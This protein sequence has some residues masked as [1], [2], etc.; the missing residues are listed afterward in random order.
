MAFSEAYLKWQLIANSNPPPSAKP[1]TAAI[2]GF[3]LPRDAM[4]QQLQ[5]QLQTAQAS[6]QQIPPQAVE[7]LNVFMSTPTWEDVIRFFRDDPMR[8]YK[9]DVETN[10]TVDIEATEDKAQVG[11]FLN[12]MAQFLN[13]IAPIVQQAILP[14]EAA[15]SIMLAVTKRFRFGV[16]VED[17]L[18]AMTAPPPPQQEGAP[19]APQPTQAEMAAQETALKG[20]QLKQQTLQMEAEYAK[21]EHAYKMEELNLKRQTLIAQAQKTNADLNRPAPSTGE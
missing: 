2:T 16:E 4:K 3:D 11:E 17:S 7:Q 14:P 15:K 13:G 1:L 19:A 5:T 20:E 12:A 9:I 21:A 18:K 6:G 10:S 8:Q